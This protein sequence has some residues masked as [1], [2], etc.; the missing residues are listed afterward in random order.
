[1]ILIL[2]VLG[3]AVASAFNTANTLPNMITELVLGS[4]LTA[5]FMPLLAKA[6]TVIL[7]NNLCCSRPPC[8]CFARTCLSRSLLVVKF[9]GVFT[10]P[11][12]T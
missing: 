11:A 5:M 4:V 12:R 7:F 10:G 6:G 3:P 8:V 2:T 9:P 1:M